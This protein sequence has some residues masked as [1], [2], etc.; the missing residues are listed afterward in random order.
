METQDQIAH[1][2]NAIK[3]KFSVKRII[4][5]GS[6][7]HGHPDSD[8]DID[9]CV[10]TDLGDKRKLDVIEG[11]QAKSTSCFFERPRFTRV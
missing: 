6:R 2:A 1:L 5:F 3:E 8:S 9:L 11:N 7:A 4:L 10:I